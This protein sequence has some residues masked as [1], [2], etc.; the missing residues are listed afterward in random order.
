MVKSRLLYLVLLQV[1]SGKA[2]A[3][4]RLVKENHGLEAWRLLVQ[5]YA[6]ERVACSRDA[7]RAAPTEVERGRG[8]LRRSA[9]QLGENDR[10]LPGGER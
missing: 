9:L 3:L 4:L 1:S 5:E 10:G 6:C 7:H 2:L 8:G